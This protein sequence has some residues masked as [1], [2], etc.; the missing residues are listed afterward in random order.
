MTFPPPIQRL[1]NFFRTLPGVGPKT[2]T[3]FVMELLKRSEDELRAFGYALVDLKQSARLCSTCFNYSMQNPC[4]ICQNKQRDQSILCIVA[5]P[6]DLICIENTQEFNGLYHVLHGVLDPIAGVKPEDLKIKELITRIEKNRSIIK[7]VILA[8]NPDIEGET[9][10]IYLSNLLKNY[11]IKITRLAKGLP[12]G[13]DLEYA[14]NITLTAA[15]KGRRE[16]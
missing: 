13:G 6:Q 2:A 10:A 8:F 4:E 12:A 9:T 5:K 7:E 15:L 1:I 11:Q 3:R 16:I 14:D